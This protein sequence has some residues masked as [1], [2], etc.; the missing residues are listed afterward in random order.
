MT[1]YWGDKIPQQ[2]CEMTRPL[3]DGTETQLN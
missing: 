2:F 1:G 3:E